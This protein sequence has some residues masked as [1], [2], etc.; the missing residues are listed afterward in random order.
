MAVDLSFD[1]LVITFFLQI[2]ESTI[3][4]SN[5]SYEA[6]VCANRYKC[7]SGVINNHLSIVVVNKELVPHETARY[8]TVLHIALTNCSGVTMNFHWWN[9]DLPEKTHWFTFCMRP[10]NPKL[11]KYGWATMEQKFVIL[12]FKWLYTH[13]RGSQ[14]IY[15]DWS[16]ERTQ[17]RCVSASRTPSDRMAI[18]QWI[19]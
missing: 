5:K 7:K 3:K 10:Q 4:S 1:I 16:I 8:C 12:S 13:Q 2:L 17:P 11:N 9:D 6:E 15:C 18:L 19:T 14:C